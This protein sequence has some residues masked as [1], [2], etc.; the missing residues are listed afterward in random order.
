MYRESEQE[1]QNF[2]ITFLQYRGFYVLRTNAGKIRVYNEQG[3]ARFIELMPAGTPDVLAFK[4]GYAYFFEL[5][6]P[7]NV[8]T[9]IQQRMQ[10]LLSRYVR[11]IWEIHSRE[12]L[13]SAID[14]INKATT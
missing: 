3:K 2:C 13:S 4:D 12:E 9:E 6:K 1:L 8:S 5:K 14:E 11:G 10:S 7:G